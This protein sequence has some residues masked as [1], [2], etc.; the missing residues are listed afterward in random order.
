[1]RRG[2]RSSR[3]SSSETAPR[4]KVNRS[5]ADG[6]ELPYA[7]RK[8]ARRVVGATDVPDARNANQP[9]LALLDAIERSL[10]SSTQQAEDEWAAERIAQTS[11]TNAT[12]RRSRPTAASSPARRC[13]TADPS[14]GPDGPNRGNRGCPRA[15]ARTVRAGR[16]AD[17]SPP[18]DREPA[19]HQRPGRVHPG[20]EPA[21]LVVIMS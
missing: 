13:P 4:T 3:A 14:V 12:P 8:T 15:G 11:R 10:A 9:M 20:G 16:A 1:M 17:T 18:R 6:A 2:G 7:L 19:Q 21:G 5:P